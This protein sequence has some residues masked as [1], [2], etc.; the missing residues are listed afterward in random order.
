[1]SRI[2]P[3]AFS[4][5]VSLIISFIFLLIIFWIFYQ[6]S[7]GNKPA[8]SALN[9]TGSYFGGVTTLVA[10]IVAA[11]L[12][13][14]WKEPHFFSKIS[15][16][17][18]EIVTLTRRMKRNIDAFTLFMKTQK[19]FYTGLNNGD[20]FANN[21]Q[22]LVNT[23]LDD[24]DDLAGLLKAYQFNF[25][26]NIPHEKEHLHRLKES[27]DILREL[28][29]VFSEPNPVIGYLESY[30]KVKIKV[31]SGDLIELYREIVLNLPDYLSEYYSS[32]T[33]R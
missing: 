7:T 20:E 5:L 18:N 29:E 27:V 1:M 33:R 32:L 10:A 3:F 2:K 28:H 9:T 22:N 6:Y 12:Y 13:T 11:Y 16:E 19:P 24:I 30:P 17:Q 31:D 25:K 4:I 15:S 14:D 8:E 23:I 21:Y 26:I